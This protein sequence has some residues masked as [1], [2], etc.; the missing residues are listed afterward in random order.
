MSIRIGMAL[1]CLAAALAS[2]IYA[3]EPQNG[4]S[5]YEADLV[6]K[7]TIPEHDLYPENIAYDSVSGDFF[8]GSLS[9]SRIIRIR[10]DGS[11][12]DFVSS[13]EASL[14]SSVGM[15]VDA[16][17]RVLWV[18]SGR[19]ALFADYAS[20][21][22]LTGVLTFNIDDG[23]VIH[24]WMLDQESDYHIFNDLALASNGDAYATTTLIGRV[25]RLPANGDE[26]ELVLQLD[27]GSHNNGI[28]L[29]GDER[30]LLMTI[31]RSL[32][33]FE[34]AARDLVE[35][36]VPED[37]A[38]GTDGLYVFDNSLVTVKPRFKQIA[39]LFV[40][41]DYTAANSVVILAQDHEQFAYPTTGVIVGDKL[42]FVATS[43]A[44][45]P[46]NTESAE[47][48]PDVL[49]YEVNLNEE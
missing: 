44:D 2:A 18:C 3:A 6:L 48:H 45:I 30:Y 31:D 38:L 8:L 24:E 37:E 12:D 7:F 1:V 4:E 26:M 47:Q 46:R 22:A 17:R 14:L 36:D 15:K 29:D 13:P 10:A 32:Y 41:A 19:Y 21:P 9:Q 5:G 35:I 16:R 40:N 39:Q 11:Y 20:A 28:A 25:Y 33:R 49:I 23:S 34:L 43:Y 42:V 27:Q